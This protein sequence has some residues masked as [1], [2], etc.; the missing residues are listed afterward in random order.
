MSIPNERKKIWG[1]CDHVAQ[2]FEGDMTLKQA[3]MY[4]A[5]QIELGNS[6]VENVTICEARFN[7]VVTE[8]KLVAI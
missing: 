4:A 3:R 5:E 1:V 2:A 8:T 6:K 7:V